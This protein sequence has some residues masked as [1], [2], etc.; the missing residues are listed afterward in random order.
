MPFSPVSLPIQEILLTNF[1]TDIATISNAN[2][3]LLQDKI[4]DL[5]NTMEIDINTLSI[6]ADNPINYVRAQS[7]IIQ[8]TGFTFQTGTPLQTIASLTKN[9][10][11]ESV[12]N[13]DRLNVDIIVT[14]DDLDVNDAVINTTLTVDGTAEFNNT[15]QYDAS[16]I[17]SKETVIADL[18]KSTA[19]TEAEARLTLTSASRRNIFVQLKATTS[20]TLDYVYDGVSAFDGAITSIDLYIDFDATNPPAQN[21]PFTIY[22]LDIVDEFSST[23][24]MAA[25]ASGALPI[26]INGG[27][28]L[29]A[30]PVASIELHSGAAINVGV[31]PASTNVASNVLRSNIPAAYGHNITLLYILDATNT[32]RLIIRDMVGMEFF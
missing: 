6:G 14:T 26:T 30:S 32:D 31:N 18:V 16:L 19:G 25:V 11:V 27:D 12:L 17:E 15:L 3:L 28:N 21:T 24:I 4:E 23:S 7:F 20:P 8:D 2:D 29:N 10:N 13:V 9:A 22:I 5:I 1:V